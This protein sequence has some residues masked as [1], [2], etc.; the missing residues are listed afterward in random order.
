MTRRRLDTELVRRGLVAS[1]SCAHAR[2]SDG[3]V[4]VGGAPAL[5][6]ARLVDASEA[7]EIL[8]HDPRYVSRGGHKLEAALDS[9]GIDPTGRRA[10]DAGASTG[11][12]TDCLLQHGC[13]SVV[14]IDVGYGQLDIRLREDPR[15]DCRER[16][17][18]RHLEPGS[19]VP[20]AELV[21][22]D[23]SFISLVVVVP[24]LVSV[25]L[26]D[27]EFVLLVKPQ[28]EA[29]RSEVNRGNGVIR[30]PRVWSRVIE[31][32]AASC[33]VLDLG[34]MGVMA[35]PLRG[36]HGNR[37]FFIHGSIGAQRT[38]S[39]EHINHVVAATSQEEADRL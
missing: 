25:S 26:D 34:I 24:G 33:S 38:L 4:I 17:N 20:P 30:D 9:F 29:E 18:A 10:I 22:A 19:V 31:E 7:V 37:E 35:S 39:A 11:G 8:D 14:A 5:N 15:V 23:L 32:V 1:P 36:P 13:S 6:S 28:F 3:R 2:I 16:T 21:V 27:A 12:F